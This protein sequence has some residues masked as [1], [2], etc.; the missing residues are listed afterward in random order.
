MSTR[1][2]IF[3]KQEAAT[4]HPFARRTYEKAC[5]LP[6][7]IFRGAWAG[8]SHRVLPPGPVDSSLWGRS[9]G[10]C[11]SVRTGAVL[12]PGKTLCVSHG[13]AFVFGEIE[14]PEGETTAEEE[15][16]E[17]EDIGDIE[18]EENNSSVTIPANSLTIIIEDG[19]IEVK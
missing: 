16:T 9:F 13:F 10:G 6:D 17:P 3:P 5:S 4:H 19:K 8:D 7:F 11:A 15:I 1:G 2:L 12:S 18:D 14:T